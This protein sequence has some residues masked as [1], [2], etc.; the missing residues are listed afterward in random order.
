MQS[1]SKYHYIFKRNRTK[2]S[3]SC[4]ES[5]K[6]PNTQSNLEIKTQSWR[7]HTIGFQIILQSYDNQNGMI[8]RKTDTQTNRTELRAQK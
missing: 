5:Q 7:Y 8:G 3:S 6:I 1:S 4:I 2:K